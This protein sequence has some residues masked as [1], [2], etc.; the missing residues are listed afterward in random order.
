VSTIKVIDFFCGAGGFSEGFRQQGFDIVM[1][2]ENWKPAVMTH[3]LNHGLNDEVM[4][5]LY[6]E[7]DV[8][9]IFTLPD[10]EV[11]IG[12]PPCV[13]FS[14][15]NKAGKADK[16]LGLR[17]IEVYLRIVTVKKYQNG[18]IL[19][20]WL[21]ENVPNS[22]NFVKTSYSFEDL[23][24]RDWAITIG[25][26]PYEIAINVKNNGE[27]LVAADYGS[28]QSRQR[29]IC[30]EIVSSG[31]FP[32]PTKTHFP[33]EGFNHSKKYITLK[34]IKG[35]MPSP[36]NSNITGM[37]IDPNY[38][39]LKIE[40]DELTDHFYDTGVFQVE[41]EMARYAK[42]NHPFMGRMSFPEDENRPSRTIMAT[43]SASTREAII[44]KSEFPRVG[45][46]EYRLP[47]IRE[48]ATLM[49][50]PY[51]YQFI[52]GESTKWKQIGNAVCPHMAS[53]LAKAI[54]IQLN[55]KP[56]E[57]H[58][59][60][61]EKQRENHR[62][63]P[64]LNNSTKLV[65]NSPPR[66]KKGTKF[67]MHPFKNGNMTVA[68]TNYNALANNT[69]S[70]NGKEWFCHIFFGSGK[71]YLI[72]P[73]TQQIFAQIDEKIRKFP[74][75]PQFI[76]DFICT[77]EGKI[78]DRRKL[79]KILEENKSTQGE[80]F[81]P[82]LLIDKVAEFIKNRIDENIIEKNITI[83][84]FNKPQFPKIQFFAI[85]AIYRIVQNINADVA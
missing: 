43:R 62:K 48:A 41:W 29:F 36:F 12:S 37:I 64:N 53:A 56:R 26:K 68:L 28:P 74:D 54:L 44:F 52:G 18:S 40:G 4:D 45:D 15:S 65:F 79:Q 51:T 2:I 9:R 19:K 60:S 77:F 66:K 5:I 3:N 17:L 80:F 84:G 24:L 27:I 16:A 39:Y 33:N 14:M 81:G 59:V 50:F 10:T 55:N 6:Y 58:E 82:V 38:Q 78:A 70:E 35:S 20:A 23:N 49:G 63:I 1:G 69:G 67:R 73:V 7:G 71:N 34:E 46:G 47:T 31:V 13:T 83:G 25:K 8:E 21:M 22:R 42:L 32:N 76:N 85:W 57:A 72:V 11:I 30:G 75:G 61:F